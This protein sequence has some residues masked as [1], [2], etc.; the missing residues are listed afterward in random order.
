MIN[1][2]RI[3][4][5]LMGRE[6]VSDNIYYDSDRKKYYVYF[7]YG[8]DD[9][10]KYIRKVKTYPNLKE[11]KRDLKTFE[12]EK[13]NDR[14]IA[15]TGITFSEYV[16]NWVKYKQLSCE[17]TT[18]YGYRSMLNKHILPT[19][20]NLPL[21]SINSDVIKDYFYKKSIGFNG[22]QP[23]SENSLRK[24]YDLLK[25]IFDRAVDEEKIRVNPL[26]ILIPPKKTKADIA[27]YTIDQLKKL[28]SVST[29]TRMEIIIKL[30]VYLG[31]R[32]EEIC[33]LKWSS[34]NLENK[35]IYINNARTYAGL[36][37]EKTTKTER[38]KRTLYMPDDLFN[39]LMT[40][41]E[42]QEKI[43]NLYH[44]TEGFE[45]V[46]SM[47]NGKPMRPNYVSDCF[48]QMIED[49]NLPHI[50]LHG[51]RHSFASVANEK[52]VSI[53]E[54]STILGHSNVKVT[55][56][57]YTHLFDKTHQESINTVADNLV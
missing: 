2:D 57:I 43:K 26:K 41:K 13:A 14:L 18:L 39:T 56:Q 3:G 24:H 30:A 45:Y 15:P 38:S 25:Q 49:A 31:L 22:A 23:L 46:V 48:K 54:I 12:S 21:Q 6:K 50:T 10:G 53:Y 33:G 27:V 5:S 19:I 11:A 29:G 1:Y 9:S 7:N 37:I 42:E 44:T 36:N 51:L 8:K 34:I 52:H 28:I 17:K 20:G 4:G 32:R 40:I 47:N 35:I 55:E 16:S